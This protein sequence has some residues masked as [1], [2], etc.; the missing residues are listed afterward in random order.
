MNNIR[1]NPQASKDESFFETGREIHKDIV[2]QQL[3]QILVAQKDC[4]IAR[5]AFLLFKR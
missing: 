4:Q 2:A 5:T 1:D 3:S